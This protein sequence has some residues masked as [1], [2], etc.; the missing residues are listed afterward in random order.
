M[1]IKCIHEHIKGGQK[2]YMPTLL[3]ESIEPVKSETERLLD[4]IGFGDWNDNRFELLKK[5]GQKYYHDERVPLGIAFAGEAWVSKAE[6][7]DRQ[8]VIFIAAKSLEGDSILQCMPISR[9]KGGNIVETA[10]ISRS[11]GESQTFLLNH[12]FRGWL[13]ECKA[14]K[15]LRR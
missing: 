7:D 9:D 4:V 2:S 8:E 15:N 1:H 3:I 6:A 13:G 14:L 10:F 11:D 5:L 12:F